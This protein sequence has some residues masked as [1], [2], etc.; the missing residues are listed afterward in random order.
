MAPASDIRCMR[1]RPD[2]LYVP[3][4]LESSLLIIYSPSKK[5]KC[6]SK[7]IM[8]EFF[9]LFC[10]F[11]LAVAQQKNCYYP[12]GTDTNQANNI[13]PVFQECGSFD[14]HSMCC[15]RNTHDRPDKCRA[16]GLCENALVGHLWRES[17][18]DPLWEAEGC[19]QLCINGTGKSAFLQL[20]KRA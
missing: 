15:R 9:A 20:C 3:T 11:S 8:F 19:L 2:N 17:C 1:L 6:R 14:T 16:D 10:A 5:S 7:L 18:T 13:G 12:N 4:Q